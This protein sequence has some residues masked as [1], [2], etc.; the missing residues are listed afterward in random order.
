MERKTEK[1]MPFLVMQILE[2][3]SQTLHQYC[4]YNLAKEKLSRS[5]VTTIISDIHQNA[6]I[7]SLIEKVRLHGI[8][9]SQ[10]LFEY[11]F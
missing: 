9:S 6:L 10:L 8:I 2:T 3:I 7:V 1:K 11:K 5:K 4:V